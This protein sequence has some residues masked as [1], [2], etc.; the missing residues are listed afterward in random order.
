MA[1]EAEVFSRLLTPGCSAGGLVFS[2]M[3]RQENR[4]LEA[5]RCKDECTENPAACCGISLFQKQ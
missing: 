5:L 2:C 4:G 3:V 1:E